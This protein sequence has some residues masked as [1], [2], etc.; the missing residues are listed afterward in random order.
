MKIFLLGATGQ[1]GSI[2]MKMALER[3][4]K[5][6]AYVRSPVK[7][8]LHNEN[9][10]IVKGDVFSLADMSKAMA[11][12]DVVVSCLGGNNND[13]ETVI[14]KMTEIIIKSMKA[15][16][17]NRIVT[18]STAGIQDEFSFVMNFIVK[19]FLKH[20]I[21]DYRLAAEAIISSGLVYT[22]ARPLALTKG[23]LT[24]VYRM[25]PEGVPRGGKEISRQDLAHFL[26]SVIEKDEF[27]NETVGLAY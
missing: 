18:I 3:N 20:T 23:P 21:H 5:V 17:I 16:E 8:L 15:N 13:K 26:L 10:N 2:F 7:V 11:S 27:K 24:E 12:H 4:H 9:L 19:S 6:T 25:T 14:T 1:T 22:I